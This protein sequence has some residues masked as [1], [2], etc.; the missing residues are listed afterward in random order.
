MNWVFD[1][2]GTLTPSRGRIDPA[3]KEFFLQFQKN[4][5]TY[6]VTGSDYDKSL[7]QLG[8]E[9]LAAAKM[10]FS[11]C[12]NEV[13]IGNLITYQSP[14]KPSLELLDE[15]ARLLEQSKYPVKTGKHVEVRTGLVNFSIVGRNADKDQRKAYVEYDKLAGERES[16]AAR[17]SVTFPDLEV[18]IAGETGLDI[19]EAGAN[20]AQIL[21]HFTERPIIFFGD[22]TR[23]GGN[24]HDLACVADLTHAVDD[25]EHTWELMKMLTSSSS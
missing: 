14:W 18:G 23:P 4:N 19:Y 2:D 17:L 3:F 21:K 5:K 6:I 20:K 12:G 1:V 22:K 9:I 16:L 8:P 25:W 10:V 24:D 7:E 13:R 15:L 11:C